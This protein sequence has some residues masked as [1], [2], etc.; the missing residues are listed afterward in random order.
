[1]PFI[2]IKIPTTLTQETKKKL[3]REVVQRTH[4]AVGSDPAIIN[5]VIH[6]MSPANISVGDRSQD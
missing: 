6:E 2:E 3:V 5:I 1:V 4:E